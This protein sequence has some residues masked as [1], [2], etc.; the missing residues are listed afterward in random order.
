[1]RIA[2]RDLVQRCESV[3]AML[4]SACSERPTTDR[5]DWVEARDLRPGDTVF[6]GDGFDAEPLTEVLREQTEEEVYDIEVEDTHSFLTDVCVIHNCGC[7]TAIIA[8][9]KL[10]RRWIGIDITPL[11]TNLI[12]YRLTE[13]FDDVQYEVV[14]EPTTVE[15]AAKLAADDPYHFQYWALGLVGARPE[16]EKKGAD[17]GI[18][19][20]RRFYD[21]NVKGNYAR[22]ILSVKAGKTSAP[23]VRDLRGVVERE[24]AAI[25]V[26][27]TMQSP[28]DPMKAEAASGGFYE[29][30]WGRHARLQIFTVAE[31]LKGAQI[32]CPKT[33][34]VDV[35]FKKARK[36]VAKDRAEQTGLEFRDDV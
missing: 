12:K 22:I 17:R 20:R 13:T 7:G 4:A 31:L 24:G 36:Q 27:I 5:A 25:G 35:T 28:T 33:E 9:Q 3:V 15:D 19:G 1:M 21:P 26:L 32:D 16:E 34:G 11:A 2:A 29:S 23:H 8:A 18:D 30:P 14:G 10:N 6:F